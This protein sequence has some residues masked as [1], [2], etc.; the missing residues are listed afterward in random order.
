MHHQHQRGRGRGRRPVYGPRRPK[1]NVPVN[2]IDYPDRFEARVFCVGFK[3]EDV[4]I[5]LARNVIYISGKRTPAVEH[6]DFLLQEYPIKSFE[7]WF[8]LSEIVDQE[9]VSASFEEGILVV[10][11]PKTEAERTPEREVP[12]D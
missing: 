2:I 10:T 12:V 9:Q 4:R 3:K 8:E 1:H 6:P 7:R 11:A 5:S